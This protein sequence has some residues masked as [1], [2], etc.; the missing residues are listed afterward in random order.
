MSSYVYLTHIGGY[1]RETVH[2]RGIS[3]HTYVGGG[4]ILS[5]NTLA[6]SSCNLYTNPRQT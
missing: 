3:W 5:L 1:L 4:E 2:G 6:I